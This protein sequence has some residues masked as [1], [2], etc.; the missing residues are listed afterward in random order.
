[1][2]KAGALEPLS[3]P[4]GVLRSLCDNENTDLILTTGFSPHDWTPEAT[5]DVIERAVP[6]IPEA[7][8]ASMELTPRAMLSRA[9]T[10]I[11]RHT[12][13]INLRAVQGR[14]GKP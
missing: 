10:G 12:L 1:M 2:W 13:I 6:G 7:M 9:V 14:P 11:R 3:K 4:F 8:R 5:L